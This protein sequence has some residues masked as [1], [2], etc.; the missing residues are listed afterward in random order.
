MS[1][2]IRVYMYG[3]TPGLRADY[4]GLRLMGLEVNSLLITKYLRRVDSEG[5]LKLL[6]KFHDDFVFRR[7]NELSLF[8]CSV[9]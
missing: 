3:S 6:T 1:L 8:L 2:I 9:N 4:K 5:N 7:P